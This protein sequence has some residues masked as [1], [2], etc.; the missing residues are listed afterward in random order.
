VLASRRYGA[1]CNINSF[2]AAIP[3]SFL[4]L[5]TPLGCNAILS[6]EWDL[7]CSDEDCP[8]LPFFNPRSAVVASSHKTQGTGYQVLAGFVVCCG[9][10][11][12]ESWH[13]R[14]E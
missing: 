3:A 2:G 7:D 14:P 1:S 13:K 9:N 8:V 12:Q 6:E 10:F 11:R 5:W 4:D